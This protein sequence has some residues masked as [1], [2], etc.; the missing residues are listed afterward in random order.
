MVEGTSITG[1][2][3][4]V[5][6]SRFTPGATDWVTETGN[7]NAV[8]ALGPTVP[9]LEVPRECFGMQAKLFVS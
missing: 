5:L 8:P 4:S 2:E 6:N 7:P 9:L 1:T 3:H